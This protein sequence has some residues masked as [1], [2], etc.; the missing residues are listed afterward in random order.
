MR[1]VLALILFS[2]QALPAAETAD[3]AVG[4]LLDRI[5]ERERASL[6]AIATRTPLVE[7]YI[8]ET[9]E[10]GGDSARPTK[11]HYFLGRFSLGGTVGY[12][13]LVERTDAPLPK[14]SSWLPFRSGTPKSRAITFLP[15][16]FAQM[17]VVDL[18]DFNR[19]TYRFEYVRREFLGEVRCLVFDVAPIHREAPGK[20]V[21]R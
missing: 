8:Q 19:D 12:E 6:A 20:F 1:T 11:D 15:R 10:N 16:G 9:P 2:A 17:A 18:R 21:G 14:S 4:K 13:S 7:S 5:V 3:A